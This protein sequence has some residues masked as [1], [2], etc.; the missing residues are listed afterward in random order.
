M[1][2]K[3]SK[4][5]VTKAGH[6]AALL[7]L[8]FAPFVRAQQASP[9]ASARPAQ[10]FVRVW[11]MM[12]GKD[13]TPL[14]LFVTDDKPMLTAVPLSYGSGYTAL[15]PGTYNFTIRKSSDAANPLKKQSLVMRANVYVTYLVT[16]KGGQPTVELIDD[17]QD[18]KK[19]NEPS[20]LVIRVFMP[21]AKVTVTTREGATSPEVGY[22]ESGKFENLPNRS[23]F[24]TMKANGLGPDVK[25]WNNEAD[26]ASYRRATLLVIGDPYGRFRPRLIYDGPSAAELAAQLPK[27]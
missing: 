18:P 17:T 6:L 4:P 24:L 12:A 27:Q 26:F 3:S 10:A 15:P 21:G 1:K 13:A 19:L 8:L 5:A 9:S 16:D 14:Q 20:Q 23:L 22:A 2:C 25:S 7:V 11:N